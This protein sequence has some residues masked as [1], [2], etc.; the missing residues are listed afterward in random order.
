MADQRA[1]PPSEGKSLRLLGDHVK[2]LAGS[3]LVGT[4]VFE[5]SKRESS[6]LEQ[7]LLCNLAAAQNQGRWC[8]AQGPRCPAAPE[9]GWPN[10]E[11]GLPAAGGYRASDWLRLKQSNC[12]R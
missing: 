11:E 6:E 8:V 1:L 7:G 3:A 4:F 12:R 5:M 2:L 10:F 9:A